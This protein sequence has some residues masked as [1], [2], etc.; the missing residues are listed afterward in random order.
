MENPWGPKL[1]LAFKYNIIFNKFIA[2]LVVFS[3]ERLYHYEL[4]KKHGQI[5]LSTSLTRSGALGSYFAR[6][7]KDYSISSIAA[8]GRFFDMVAASCWCLN[9]IIAQ[10]FSIYSIHRLTRINSLLVRNQIRLGQLACC[11]TE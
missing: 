9:E 11:P 1:N 4:N 2:N 7:S 5:S 6:Y 10:S 3:M 8:L